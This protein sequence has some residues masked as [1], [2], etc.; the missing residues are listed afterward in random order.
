MK[1]DECCFLV[2]LLSKKLIVVNGIWAHKHVQLSVK[3]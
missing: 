2:D 1:K 3:Q